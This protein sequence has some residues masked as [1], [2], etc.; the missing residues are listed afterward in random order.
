MPAGGYYLATTIRVPVYIPLLQLLYL[1]RVEASCGWALI[2]SSKHQH[3]DVFRVGFS[4]Y[5]LYYHVKLSF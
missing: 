5:S 3:A 2:K 1:Q 4:L